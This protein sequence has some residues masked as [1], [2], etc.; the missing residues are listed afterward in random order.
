MIFHYSPADR[1]TESGTARFS[2]K[3]WLEYLILALGGYSGPRVLNINRDPGVTVEASHESQ[4]PLIGRDQAHCLNSVFDQV[5]NDLL[6]L[7]M[8]CLY[9]RNVLIVFGGSN[10]SVNSKLIL[11]QL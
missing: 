1:E 8:R 3:K 6:Y 10:Y 2:R 4:S 11:N 9:F 5:Q 7:G